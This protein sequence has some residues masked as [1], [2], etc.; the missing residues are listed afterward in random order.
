MKINLWQSA[1][2][3]EAVGGQL[4]RLEEQVARQAHHVAKLENLLLARTARIDALTDQV[5]Q[6]RAA[7]ARLDA[8]ADRLAE[9]VRLSP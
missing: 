9:M 6:L 8:E 1:R 7:N 4:V 3:S 5:A 2:R